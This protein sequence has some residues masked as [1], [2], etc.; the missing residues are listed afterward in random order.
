MKISGFSIIR[1]GILLDYPFTEALLSIAPLC[2]E[3][4]VAV[5]NSE[6]NT[7]NALIEL[8]LPNLTIIDTIW[9]ENLRTG[10]QILSQQTNIALAACTGDWGFYIQA[11]EVLHEKYIPTIQKALKKYHD[12]PKT[13]GLLFKYLH[14]YGSYR[15]IAASPKWYRREIRIIR[16][17]QE[18]RSWG[19][20]QGFRKKKQKL[21]VRPIDATI[22]HYGWV[23]TPDALKEKARRFERYWHDD[24]WLAENVIKAAA[25]DYD[26]CAWLSEFKETHPAVLKERLK[27]MNW[28]FEYDPTKVKIPF[29]QWLRYQIEKLTGYRIGEYKNYK[30]I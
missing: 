26:I 9:D 4:I 8:N 23:R 27:R 11:D 3:M 19:D 30:I 12:D 15:Y 2:D 13:E 17:G 22:Y 21:W 16:L 20:A 25:A 28:K 10:G 6:D 24:N 14:F 1:N 5:G 7:R 29:I 18:I